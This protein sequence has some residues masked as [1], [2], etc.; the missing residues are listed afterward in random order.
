MNLKIVHKAKTLRVPNNEK[1]ITEFVKIYRSI[2]LIN[3]KKQVSM[4]SIVVQAA[5]FLIIA[6]TTSCQNV[7]EHDV[8]THEET[9]K[10]EAAVYEIDNN[11]QSL[12]SR[13]TYINRTATITPIINDASYSKKGSL[14]AK[15][16]NGVEEMYY[17]EHVADVAP[18]IINEKFLSVTH[19]T[20]NNNKAY[21]S[22]H[23][24]GD[25]HFG[26]IETIDLN[27]PNFPI[28]A[29]RATFPRSDINAI[30]SGPSA[31][32][33]NVKVWLAMSNSK[34]GAQLYEIETDNG[35]Y[36]DKHR[37]VNLSNIFDTGISASANGIAST[38]QFLYVTS[39]KT[40]GGTVKLNKSSLKALDFESYQ[41]A[42]YIAANSFSG[43]PVIASL[44]T[45]DNAS[46]K[47]N[48][49]ENDLNATNFSI[50]EIFHQNV[51]ET[52]RGKST[53]E[54]SPK[55]SNNLYIAKG[56]DG[57]GLYDINNG[58]ELNKSKGTM[59]IAGNTNG[60][61]TDIDYVYA[62][63]G[64]DGISISPHPTNQNEDICPIF[65]WDLAE[66]DASANYII[67]D[68]EWV[69]VAKGKGGFKILRKR[70]KDEYK[71]VTTY[72]DNGKPDGMEDD[73]EVCSTLL[74]NIYSNVLP[75]RQNAMKQHPEYFLNPVKNLV[76]KEK[77]E[78]NLTFIDEGAGYKN[79]LGYY[80]YN[81]NDPITEENLLDKIVI[82]PNVSA[83]GS[84]GQL[85]RGNTM[86]LLGEFEPG[87]VVG[88]F[89]IAN[90]WRNGSIT[91]GYYSQHTD[92]NFNRSGR[93][94]SIIFYDA[95]CNSV[96]IAFED[97]SVPNGDNDFNDAIFEITSSNPNA[98]EVE[99]FNQ[100]GN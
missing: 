82:F 69:F 21:I 72:N 13:I 64:S 33:P 46:L 2:D 71:T 74:P 40:H 100:I 32:S 79:V 41:N 98:L 12:S 63:N 44:V 1:I 60:V 80:T 75:E 94:Q 58:V 54:F 28:I 73:K 23:K 36:T 26:A 97:I 93:Q 57:I 96:V 55:N 24:Q 68:G 9:V 83:Q 3:K 48:R 88:F 34:N 86:R 7:I 77:T 95:N 22:Y 62:A 67:A 56:K 70:T 78:L 19:I 27:N 18:L 16:V 37:R 99:S 52:Y 4:S 51:I 29:S 61:S 76:I 87:T 66:E 20:L 59:L 84:G 91:D 90:G 39:G 49:D 31:A 15:S 92:I 45:G 43:N 38:S 14:K 85:I 81:E 17:W 65:Y 30:S 42:K 53:M 6:I 89:L 47:I 50:G 5:L 25:E 11:E 8:M 10:E 35:V